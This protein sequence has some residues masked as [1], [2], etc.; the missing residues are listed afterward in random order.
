MVGEHQF[1][2]ALQIADLAKSHHLLLP[3]LLSV[4]LSPTMVLKYSLIAALHFA[5]LAEI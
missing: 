2:V 4:F 1:A 3:H 5:D